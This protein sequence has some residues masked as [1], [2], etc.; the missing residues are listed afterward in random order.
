MVRA[1]YPKQ[2]HDLSALLQAKLRVAEAG[3]S[4]AK[5]GHHQRELQA[6]VAKLKEVSFPLP[7]RLVSS[8]VLLVEAEWTATELVKEQRAAV[9][10]HDSVFAAACAEE[11]KKEAHRIREE[12]PLDKLLTSEEVGLPSPKLPQSQS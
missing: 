11:V 1:S 6:A 8:A 3:N 9:G 7:W 12:L 5:L 2:M 10:A 4:I